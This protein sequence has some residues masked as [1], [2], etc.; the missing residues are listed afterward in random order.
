M[1]CGLVSVGK[2]HFSLKKNMLSSH[3]KYPVLSVETEMENSFLEQPVAWKPT[4]PVAVPHGFPGGH[5]Q[6]GTNKSSSFCSF[7]QKVQKNV[8]NQSY[9]LLRLTSLGSQVSLM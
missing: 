2:D 6:P 9:L 1:R 5:I 3:T 7:M 4:S 8:T